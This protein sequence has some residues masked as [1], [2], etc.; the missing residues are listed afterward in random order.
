MANRNKTE[1]NSRSRPPRLRPT[2]SSPED[3]LRIFQVYKIRQST[4]DGIREAAR[5]RGWSAAGLVRH[6]LDR[7]V[8]ARGK[9][10]RAA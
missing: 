8:E 7:W 3:P 5:E 1:S 2:G 6:L 4:V 10:R 9:R